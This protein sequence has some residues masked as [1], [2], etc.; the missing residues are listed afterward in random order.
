MDTPEYPTSLVERPDRLLLCRFDDLI[1]R[2]PAPWQ[3]RGV[4]R[5]SSVMLLY[6]RRGCY[7]SFL[8]LDM[9]ASLATGIPWQGHP[10]LKGGLVIYVAGE[11]GGGMVQRCRA[12][13][14]VRKVLP[15]AV[16]MRF[17]TEPVICTATSED[18]DVLIYRIQE[19]IDYS[20]A[21]FIDPLTGHEFAHPTAREWPVLIIIDTLARCFI[22]NE[23]HPDAMGEFIQGVDRLKSEFNCS[24]IVVHHTGRDESRERGHT[25]LPGACD[26]IYRLDAEKNSSALTLTCEKMKDGREP[27]P[28]ELIHRTVDVTRRKGDDPDEELTSVV[29]DLPPPT[30]TADDTLNALVCIGG[31]ATWNDWWVSTGT[32]KTTFSRHLVGLMKKGKILKKKGV[33]SVI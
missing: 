15:S 21:G 30:R 31:E 19:A 18:M 2:P 7:K 17:I 14:E 3:I 8:A 27:D 23:N 22:G 4:L 13:T 24:I 29:I 9:A 1:S 26:T 28:V 32:P 20:P 5:E 6:G 25:N 10:V 16:N 11:G 12:W 33:Y